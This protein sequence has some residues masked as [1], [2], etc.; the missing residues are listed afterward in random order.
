DLAISQCALAR[1]RE[2]GPAVREAIQRELAYARQRGFYYVELGGWAISEEMR[3]SAEA[4]RMLLTVFALAQSM[5]GALGLSNATTRHHS[6][7]ILRRVGGRPL[8]ARGAVIP[9]YLDSHYNCEMELLTFDS[10]S[11]NAHYGRW[12]SECRAALPE[13]PVISDD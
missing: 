7:S 8:V 6:S 11:P 2:F 4:L 5:G 13:L 9:A 12:I 3:C 10:T 1:S